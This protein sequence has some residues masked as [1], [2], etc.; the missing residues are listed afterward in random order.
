MSVSSSRR[1]PLFQLH[2]QT[3]VNDIC[4]C[5][6]ESSLLA[7]GE[8]SGDVRIWDL[9]RRRAKATLRRGSISSAGSIAP[10]AA[11]TRVA[12][13][14]G[15]VDGC[16]SESPELFVADKDGVVQRWDLRKET[17]PLRS[18][19]IGPGGGFAKPQ[20]LSGDTFVAAQAS[21]E[22]GLYDWREGGQGNHQRGGSA[23]SSSS[24][25]AG[26]AGGLWVTTPSVVTFSP[27][28]AGATVGLC[29]SLASGV[30]NGNNDPVTEFYTGYESGAVFVWD[31][32]R[33]REPLFFL[34]AALQRRRT[35]TSSP[36]SSA[37]LMGQE[38]NSASIGCLAP[39]GRR[40]LWAADVSGSLSVLRLR[41][42]PPPAASSS[43]T[44]EFDISFQHQRWLEQELSEQEAQ[45][46]RMRTSCARRTSGGSGQKVSA[47]AVRG[48]GRLLASGTW[49]GEV[50]LFSRC[51]R[52]LGTRQHHEGFVHALAFRDGMFASAGAD[53][54]IVVADAL[55]DTFDAKNC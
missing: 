11:V 54:R 42:G 33:P 9:A 3:Q 32:R 18:L 43:P 26:A 53:G 20:I 22:V 41:D 14:G 2:A 55:A 16:G 38:D 31:V 35:S 8:S 7:T 10:A 15:G 21:G 28:S 40:L 24:S 1:T 39:I 5:G 50:R 27:N 44:G 51:G 45:W 37:P 29:M 52:L 23:S 17:C 6:D 4:F 47:M 48:D 13:L 49:E 36:G 12:T 25:N 19:I 46:P 30:S 34:E